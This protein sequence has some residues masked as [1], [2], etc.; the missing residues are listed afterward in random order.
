MRVLI[1]CEFSGI[2]RRAFRERGYDAWSCDLLPAEDDT[3][4]HYQ[5]DVA[6][7]VGASWD[8][9]IAHPPCT[10]LTKSGARWWKGREA[11]Q[12]ESLDFVRL[13]LA[14]PIKYIAVRQTRQFSPGSSAMVRLRRPAFGSRI[15][16]TCSQQRLLLAVTRV[17]ITPLQDRI[18]GRS[19][20]ALCRASRKLWPNSGAITLPANTN[21]NLPLRG[22]YGRNILHQGP[23]RLETPAAHPKRRSGDYSLRLQGLPSGRFLSR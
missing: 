12:E 16:R 9:M 2:V 5:M 8:L 21:S 6:L 4:H 10:L 22:R 7:V 19:A 15:C 23:Q 3:R 17:C 11:E 20:A 18:G 1:A 13:L 14:A